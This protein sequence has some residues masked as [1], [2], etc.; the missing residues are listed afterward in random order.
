M[1]TKPDDGQSYDHDD[2]ADTDAQNSQDQRVVSCNE[3]RTM[4][5]KVRNIK[6]THNA[7][8][9]TVI[10]HVQWERGGGENRV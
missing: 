7:H 5:L 8:Q 9:V 6:Y 3:N 2:D 1:S 10:H 4:I